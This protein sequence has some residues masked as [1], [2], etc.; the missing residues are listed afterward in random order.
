MRVFSEKAA[1]IGN[2]QKDLSTANKNIEKLTSEKSGLEQTLSEK[3]TE[4][5]GLWG[6]LE[7]ANN[8]CGRVI[9]EKT[10]LEESL[11]TESNSFNNL[12]QEKASEISDLKESLS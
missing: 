9:A 7:N 5:E 6:D 2:L 1:E 10:A 12:L 11:S 3:A 4:I 8:A